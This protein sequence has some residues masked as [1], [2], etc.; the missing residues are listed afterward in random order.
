MILAIESIALL[1][2]EV[3]DWIAAQKKQPSWEIRTSSRGRLYEVTVEVADEPVVDVSARDLGQAHRKALDAWRAWSSQ[4]ESYLVE[5]LEV[6][7][8]TVRAENAAGVAR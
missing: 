2:D 5:A 8:E 3:V 1:T 7:I 4:T 6:S